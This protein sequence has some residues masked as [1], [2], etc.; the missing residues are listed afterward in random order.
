MEL[1]KFGLVWVCRKA[2]ELRKNY[3]V[4]FRCLMWLS[5]CFCVV[6]AM[7]CVCGIY[8]KDIPKMIWMTWMIY[9]LK[10]ER[11]RL[12]CSTRNVLGISSPVAL[13]FRIFLMMN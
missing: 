10:V 2:F 6:A 8:P 12:D 11:I 5:R 4:G 7:L 9:T 13:I 1:L 3:G